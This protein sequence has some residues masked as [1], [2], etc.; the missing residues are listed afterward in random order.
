VE[1]L[2]VIERHD[3]QLFD[4]G[5]VTFPAYAGAT[6]GVR[7]AGDRESFRRERDRAAGRADLDLIAVTLAAL[8]GDDF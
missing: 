6:S 5:P 4:V 3:V 8:A 2:E 1:A 7:S